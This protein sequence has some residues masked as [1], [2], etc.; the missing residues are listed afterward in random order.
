LIV[1][2]LLDYQ[3]SGQLVL[4]ALLPKGFD[5]NVEAVVGSL[6]RMIYQNEN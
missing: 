6:N 4:E 1:K 2:R 5:L 3:Q